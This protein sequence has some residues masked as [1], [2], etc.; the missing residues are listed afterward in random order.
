MKGLDQ[1]RLAMRVDVQFL[2]LGGKAVRE[3]QA[4]DQRKISRAAIET[5]RRRPGKQED[6]ASVTSP[7][8]RGLG[9]EDLQLHRAKG[10]K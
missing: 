10:V 5:L 8:V 7:L 1:E 3:R 2:S 4:D 9:A 6:G